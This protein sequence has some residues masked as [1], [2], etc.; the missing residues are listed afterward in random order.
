MAWIVA[1]GLLFSDIR[2]VGIARRE[3]RSLVVKADEAVAAVEG[4]SSEPVTEGNG[5]AG[6]TDIQIDPKKAEPDEDGSDGPEGP[7]I[8]SS[9]RRSLVPIFF[10]VSIL[11]DAHPLY[12]YLLPLIHPPKHG[13]DGN[14]DILHLVLF[15]IRYALQVLLVLLAL[16]STLGRGHAGYQRLPDEESAAVRGKKD[17]GIYRDFWAR[18]N[19]LIPFLWPK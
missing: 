3:A 16:S 5:L 14:L 18:M 2:A 8:S 1:G 10:F 17:E 12:E 7:P 19:L 13:K 11:A 6:S 4:V 9:W 15:L